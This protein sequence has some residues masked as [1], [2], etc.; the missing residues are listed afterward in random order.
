[1]EGVADQ[2]VTAGDDLVVAEAAGHRQ[3]QF[4][5]L[6]LLHQVQHLLQLLPGFAWLA[7]QA[8]GQQHGE[9][10]RINLQHAADHGRIHPLGAGGDQV[11]PLLGQG[12]GHQLHQM[13]RNHRH[14]A[15]AQDGN[16]AFAPVL[17]HGQFL[18]KGV[19]PAQCRKIKGPGHL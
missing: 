13:D 18:G 19:D 1:M 8:L 17:E 11:V 10:G 9:P 16:P 4:V 12:A 6:G 5:V 7:I 15:T 14:V 3:G 2:L